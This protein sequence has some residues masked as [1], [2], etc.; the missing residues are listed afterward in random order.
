MHARGKLENTIPTIPNIL[1]PAKFVSVILSPNSKS[2][3]VQL[4]SYPFR[5]ISITHDLSVPI[6]ISWLSIH[7]NTHLHGNAPPKKIHVCV[8]SP[9]LHSLSY[10]LWSRLNIKQL[11][12]RIA[13]LQSGFI[14]NGHKAIRHFV[15][16]WMASIS[17]YMIQRKHRRQRGLITG[18]VW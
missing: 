3:F 6:K 4:P 5:I 7:Y 1:S 8:P 18:I 16:L 10:E 11:K 15:M 13:S 9:V 14:R 17:Q 2:T 12:V